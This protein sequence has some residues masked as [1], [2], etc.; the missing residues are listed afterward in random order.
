MVYIDNFNAAFGN[1]LMCHMVADSNQELLQ[2]VDKIGVDRKWIQYAGTYAEHFDI[3]LAM[4]KK[5][6]AAG[7]KEITF[8][9]YGRFCEKRKTLGPAELQK[10]MQE[11]LTTGKAQ[12]QLEMNLE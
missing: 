10:W 12:P 9:A 6:L 2:M 11:Q 3:C 4:K 5:V 1:M 8:M 7:A